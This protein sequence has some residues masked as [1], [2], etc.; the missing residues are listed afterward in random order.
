MPPY[1][2]GR[3]LRSIRQLSN[4]VGCSADY[5]SKT[6]AAYGIRLRELID[7]VLAIRVVQWWQRSEISLERIGWHM[8][9]KHA[10]GVSELVLRA[11]GRRPSNLGSVG[12]R[13]AIERLD[14]AFLSKLLA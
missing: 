11:T 8:G 5:L 4:V 10:S 9:F 7:L 6:A 14:E 13:R 2:S 12:L 1:Q 3:A